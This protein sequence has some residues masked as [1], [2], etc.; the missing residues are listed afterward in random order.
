MLC[1]DMSVIS[2]TYK[3]CISLLHETCCFGRQLIIQLSAQ[4]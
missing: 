1:I 3:H 4:T 2:E